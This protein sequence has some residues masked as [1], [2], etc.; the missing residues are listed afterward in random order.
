M[1]E[2]V[3]S[4][5]RR[6]LISHWLIFWTILRFHLNFSVTFSHLLRWDELLGNYMFVTAWV[7]NNENNYMKKKM[8]KTSVTS[9]QKIFLNYWKEWLTYRNCDFCA[10]KIKVFTSKSNNCADIENFIPEFATICVQTKPF[11]HLLVC[12]IISWDTYSWVYE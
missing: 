6:A 5:S 12:L 2:T 8:S 7:K 10:I 1:R 9:V 4:N 3:F 11:A